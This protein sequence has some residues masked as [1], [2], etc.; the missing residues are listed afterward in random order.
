VTNPVYTNLWC[1]VCGVVVGKR[2]GVEV[3]PNLL[4]D[5][6]LCRLQEPTSITEPRDQMVYFAACH[7]IPVT[8]IAK[9]V[10]VSRQ[11]VYQILDQE[12]QVA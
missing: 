11:R 9:Y 6:P 7:G 4:C 5:N 8:S 2:Q 3:I 10:G 1:S 12:A